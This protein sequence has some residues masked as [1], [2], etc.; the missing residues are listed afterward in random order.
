[1]Q[2]KHDGVQGI[3]ITCNRGVV[4]IVNVTYNLKG[5]VPGKFHSSG[6]SSLTATVGNVS[7]LFIYLFIFYINYVKT[8]YI[9]KHNNKEWLCLSLYKI[10]A[11]SPPNNLNF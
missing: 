6:G 11:S 3:N 4:N 2:S 9:E 5:D 10:I 8:L 7:M 1:L